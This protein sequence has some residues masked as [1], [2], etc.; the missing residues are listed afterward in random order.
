MKHIYWVGVKESE[1][2][3][4]KFLF[5]GSITFIGTGKNG[6]I[7]FSSSNDYI[8]NYNEDSSEL[9]N[10]MKKTL[11]MIID[12]IPDVSFFCYTTS[13]IY[14]LEDSEINKHIICG[15]SRDALQLLRN[16]MNTRL[17]LNRYVSILP[18]ILLI[19][20]E[21]QYEKLLSFFPNESAFTIQG[22][23]G[24]GGMDTYLMTTDNHKSVITKLYSNHIYLISPYKSESYSVNVHVLF[25]DNEYFISPGSIQIAEKQND[26][27]VYRGCD[28]VEYRQIPKEIQ[29]EILNDSKKIAEKI[30]LV[31]YKGILGIDF[32]ISDSE[33]YFLEINPRFQSSSSILNLA[34]KEHELPSLQ[35]M[36]LNIYY[37]DS[38][39]NADIF[40]NL[41]VSFS[42]Y[43]IDYEESKYD[44]NAYLQNINN[45]PEITEL[46]L[47]GY[48]PTD[49]VQSGASIFSVVFDKNIISLNPNGNYN[50]YDNIKPFPLKNIFL[51]K[52]EEC[53]WLKFA[54]MN[55]GICFSETAKKHLS[56]FQQGVYSSLDIYITDNFIINAPVEMPFYSLSPF[57]VD[58]DDNKL[59]LY[60]GEKFI[61]YIK[62]DEKKE[63]C[64]QFTKNGINFQRISFIAT[65]RLR[66]HHSSN[67]LFQTQNTG[68]KFCDVPGNSVR[69]MKEDIMEVIDWHLQN[70]DFRH[71]LIGGA[72]GDYPQEYIEILDIV[73]YIKS[74]S[75]KK[76]YIMTLP[77]RDLSV[78]DQYYAAGVDEVAFNIEIYNRDCAKKIMPG[79][80]QIPLDTYKETLLHSVELWGNTGNVRSI[81]LYG[82]E[83]DDD[84][85][86]GIEWLASNGIQPI[87][88]PFRALKG[89]EYAHIVPPTTEKLIEVYDRASG[90]CKKNNLNL[91]PDC[92]FCQN[93]TLSFDSRIVSRSDN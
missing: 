85:F 88:S 77:P 34:L 74:R 35:E 43:I 39:L 52:H 69:F 33:V 20:G 83:S 86:K 17:W 23:F 54:M 12:K 79:K 53:K 8:I 46:I 13:Y 37:N 24:S 21:C 49:N 81:L 19:G 56:L 3:T 75:N 11:H 90:I 1:I 66:I 61:T 36:I 5:E 16:K 72:S 55:Q 38:F 29:D 93:N 64:N 76:V 10:F 26:R 18:T 32:L 50:I 89:T 14:S 78:L 70:S 91:G 51:N 42:N 59:G 47:D 80:G 92:I 84:F 63:Y 60:Y 71:I 45:S 82:L 6:N 40:D 73:K 22:C 87:I 27:I 41:Q 28:F 15:N 48:C 65:D 67:C 2:Q 44:Y 58:I 4:C 9:D 68:C 30:K 7:S 31:P 62:I 57:R 25:A